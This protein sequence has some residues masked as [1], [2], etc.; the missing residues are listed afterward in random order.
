MKEWSRKK[1]LIVKSLRMIP[2]FHPAKKNDQVPGGQQEQGHGI[3]LHDPGEGYQEPT[4]FRSGSSQ[5]V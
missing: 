3:F 4:T 5:V 2:I 1:V